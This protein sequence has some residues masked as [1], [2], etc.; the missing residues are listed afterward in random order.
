MNISSRGMTLI[1]V[2]VYIALY[3]LLLFVLVA[4]DSAFTQESAREH[5]RAERYRDVQTVLSR[6]ETIASQCELQQPLIDESDTL[7]ARCDGV[8]V[9]IHTHDG[10]V[11]QSSRSVATVLTAYSTNISSLQFIPLHADGWHVGMA[12]EIFADGEEFHAAIFSP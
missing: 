6:I 1:E 7:S 3:S 8:L 5:A 2:C 11:W 12:V 10:I 9:Q 4:S